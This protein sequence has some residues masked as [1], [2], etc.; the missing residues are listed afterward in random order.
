MNK[1]HAAL[2]GASP[3]HGGRAGKKVLF[4]VTELE[5]PVGGLYRFASELLPSW[6]AAFHEG[7]TDFEPVVLSMHDPSAPQNDLEAS[8][9]FAELS[10]QY[11]EIKVYEAVR[12]GEK[13]YFLEANQSIGAGNDFHGELFKKFRIRSEKNSSDKFYRLLTAYWRYAPIVADYMHYRLGYKVEMIDAQDWL[14]FP[15]GFLCRERLSKPL[16]CRYHSGEFGRA[17]GNPDWDGAPIQI[18]AAGLAFSDYVQ[19][20]SVSEGKFELYNLLDKKRSMCEELKASMPAQWAAQQSWKDGKYEEFLLLESDSLELVGEAM[21]GLPNGIV[22]EP[23]KAVHIADIYKGREMLRNIFP[24]KLYALFI[25]RPERRKGIEELLAA[26][27]SLKDLDLGLVVASQMTQAEYDTFKAKTVSMGI[28][29]KVALYN[30]WISDVTKKSLICATDILALPSLY[31]PF[32]LVTLEGLAADMACELNGVHGPVV[33]VGANGGMN[34]VI[35]NGV[36]GFKAPMNG[37]FELRADHLAKIISMVA[38]DE[39]LRARISKGASERVQ[40]PYF[41]WR[42]TVLRI[43]ECY[44][45][46]IRNYFTWSKPSANPSEKQAGVTEW[47]SASNS[48]LV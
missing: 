11:P 25:G 19:A 2:P 16:L 45:R 4:L 36:N 29:N 47:P 33:I 28:E 17:L 34:E 23:W 6:R 26:V 39:R 38:G 46:A 1:K 8:R 41:D 21:A 12:G 5:R 42:F 48:I 32:G 24:K 9:D 40:S 31:E 13:C 3:G 20:V 37:A 43:H 35:K 22:L 7:R 18:E 27:A 14:A 10:S 30:G 44:R 15:A